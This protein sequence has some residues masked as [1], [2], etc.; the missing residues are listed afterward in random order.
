MKIH[1]LPLAAHCMFVN[2]PVFVFLGAH[3][4]SVHEPGTQVIAVKTVQK[5]DFVEWL[6]LSNI[7]RCKY[8]SHKCTRKEVE[9]KIQTIR[10]AL[11]GCEKF[12]PSLKTA[13]A[14]MASNS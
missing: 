2:Y 1:I 13:I 9:N 6:L 5:V 3:D 8:I 11:R 12:I 14:E 7:T 4:R 10:F